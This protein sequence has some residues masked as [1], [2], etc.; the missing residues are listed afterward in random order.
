MFCCYYQIEGIVRNLENSL[1]A[2]EL[3]IW[4]LTG[5]GCEN[6]VTAFISLHEASAIPLLFVQATEI[7]DSRKKRNLQGR[8]ILT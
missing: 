7:Q 3:L 4:T 2:G 8:E 6:L 5:T 1:A